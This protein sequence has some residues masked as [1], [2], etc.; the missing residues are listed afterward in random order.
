LQF[1]MAAGGDPGLAQLWRVL[2]DEMSIAMA[3]TGM[4]CIKDAHQDA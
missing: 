2:T 4:T 3:Q 1:A